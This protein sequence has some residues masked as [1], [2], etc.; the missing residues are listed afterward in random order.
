MVISVSKGTPKGFYISSKG[1]LEVL[2]LYLDEF[3]M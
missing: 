2:I 1:C 3:E